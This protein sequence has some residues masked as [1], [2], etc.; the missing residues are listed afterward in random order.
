MI[1]RRDLKQ[2][3]EG[4]LGLKLPQRG[5]GRQVAGIGDRDDAVTILGILE[6]AEGDQGCAHDRFLL[7][8]YR[9]EQDNRGIVLLR[10]LDETVALA[11]VDQVDRAGEDVAVDQ[12][13]QRIETLSEK[14]ERQE[15][16]RGVGHPP[17]VEGVQVRHYLFPSRCSTIG[18]ASLSAIHLPSITSG[19]VSEGSFST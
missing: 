18:C 1:G 11:H 14:V 2:L 9:V 10:S 16:D 12:Q 8:Q 17:G 6:F 5:D 13:G 4:K 15:G 7:R 3:E 19:F